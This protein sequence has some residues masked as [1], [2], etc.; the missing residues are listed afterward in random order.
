MTV[1]FLESLG[2]ES[3]ACDAILAEI[4][5]ELEDAQKACEEKDKLVLQHEETISELLQEK[6]ETGAKMRLASV[7][8]T[9]R[10]SSRYAE[11]AFFEDFK[12]ALTD[13]EHEGLSD[14]DIFAKLYAEKSD[15]FLESPAPYVPPDE[16]IDGAPE[17]GA[18][19]AVMGI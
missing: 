14:A 19:R 11:T 1:E 17:N 16:D 15:A 3:A 18:M 10:F 8:G 6:E 4:A 12:E 2:V 13:P 7:L 9:R 5:R